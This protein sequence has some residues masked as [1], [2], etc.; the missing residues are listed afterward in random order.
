MKVLRWHT[1]VPVVDP[2]RVTEAL[3]AAL[4][5]TTKTVFVGL[6]TNHPRELTCEARAAIARIVDAGIPIVSQTVLLRGVN[7]NADTLEAL[8]RA[9]VEIRVKP[10]YL[11]HGDL[12]PGHRALPHDDRRGPSL[13]GGASTAALR[14]GT[15]DVRARP[16][17]RA[18]QGS[19]GE[20]RT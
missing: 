14:A 4:R 10:Y 18:R 8:M 17:R 5:A 12:A 2:E 3:I 20:S 9:L 6:H 1:R 7:D 15:A 19:A 11:H 16:S 13:D